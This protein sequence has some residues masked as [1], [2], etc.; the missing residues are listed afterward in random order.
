M[1]PANISPIITE[2]QGVAEEEVCFLGGCSIDI[3][4]LPHSFVPLWGYLMN[5]IYRA[6]PGEGRAWRFWRM[7]CSP[8]LLVRTKNPGSGEN[9]GSDS[10][11]LIGAEESPFLVR[12]NVRPR[13]QVHRTH[14]EKQDHRQMFMYLSSLIKSHTCPPN[15]PQNLKKKKPTDILLKV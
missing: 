14:M 3:S 1:T 4:S 2:H 5:A 7:C 8:Q 6:S 9:A 15:V 11:G 13:L 12:F 10:V